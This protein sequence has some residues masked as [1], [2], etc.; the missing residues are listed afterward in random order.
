MP[1]RNL[2]SWLLTSE[3]IQELFHRAMVGK[4][5]A[6]IEGVMGLYDGATG[7]DESGSTAQLAKLLGLPVVLVVDAPKLRA[8][9]GP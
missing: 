3:A 6:V 4:D 1:C 5:V 2:D 9:S 7:D 8:V